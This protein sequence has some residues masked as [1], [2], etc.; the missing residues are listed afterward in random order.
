LEMR[1]TISRYANQENNK[2]QSNDHTIGLN[3]NGVPNT[4]TK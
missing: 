1:N 4:N 3:D 2:G